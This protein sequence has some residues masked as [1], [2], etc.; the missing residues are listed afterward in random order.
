MNEDMAKAFSRKRKWHFS[1][2]DFN[3]AMDAGLSYEVTIRN[4]QKGRG[5]KFNAFQVGTMPED[6]RVEKRYRAGE[7]VKS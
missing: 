4:T 7:S 6:Y 3:K 2:K 5:Y 1:E